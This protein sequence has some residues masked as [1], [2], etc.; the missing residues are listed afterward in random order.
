[1]E[2]VSEWPCFF[3]RQLELMCLA[4]SQYPFHPMQLQRWYNNI[5]PWFEFLRK[6]ILGMFT[7][8]ILV[9]YK[10]CSSLLCL[11]SAHVKH[12]IKTH[13]QCKSKKRPSL[14]QILNRFF[15]FCI[16]FWIESVTVSICWWRMDCK[17]VK[18][19][20][21]GYWWASY[22]CMA[23]N[24]SYFDMDVQFSL[25]KL[26]LFTRS[27]NWWPMILLTFSDSW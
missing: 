23:K 17:A 27:A 7:L 16:Q 11:A 6:N 5:L 20:N 10:P 26:Q 25:L 9:N 18:Q 4:P 1:M 15:V 22:H 2:L 8:S 21:V 19:K 13:Y 12:L 3:E 14:S 24:S